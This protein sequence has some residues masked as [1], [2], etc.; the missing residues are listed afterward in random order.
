MVTEVF[1][2]T[3]PA[4]NNPKMEMLVTEESSFQVGFTVCDEPSLK[5]AV[6]EYSA[7]LLSF[8][9][10]GP[11]ILRDVKVGGDK[12]IT[13]TCW[14]ALRITPPIVVL[15][16][17]VVV[18]S[19]LTSPTVNKPELDMLPGPEIIDQLGEAE[20]ADPSLKTAVAVN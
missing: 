18:E 20:T 11:L 5:Y 1:T 15:A 10:L 7:V 16:E 2:A 14:V 9:E 19:L 3:Q 6:A 17:T 13:E 8:S 4:L 12:L